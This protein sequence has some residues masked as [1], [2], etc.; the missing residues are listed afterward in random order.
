[1]S[2]TPAPQEAPIESPL[3]PTSVE[4]LQDFCRNYMELTE[5]YSYAP[6]LQFPKDPSKPYEVQGRTPTMGMYGLHRMDPRTPFSLARSGFDI[7]ETDNALEL[8]MRIAQTAQGAQSKG[9]DP[10]VRRTLENNYRDRMMRYTVGIAKSLD[11]TRI[12]GKSLQNDPK[13][14]IVMK[15]EIAKRNIDDVYE[16]AGFA[17]DEKGDF[18]MILK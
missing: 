8:I 3:Y 1:M 11:C 12:V 17:R 10:R 13:A 18:I 2:E 9:I 5:G 14:G 4:E 16:T 15:P 7:I 6:G